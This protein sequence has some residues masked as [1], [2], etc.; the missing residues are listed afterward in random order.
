MWWDVQWMSLC[1][2]SGFTYLPPWRRIHPWHLN[3]NYTFIYKTP[4]AINCPL[5]SKFYYVRIFSNCY[6]H[7]AL[8][9]V[10]QQP[11]FER[12]WPS[13]DHS[14]NGYYLAMLYRHENTDYNHLSS[15][16]NSSNIRKLHHWLEQNNGI[17]PNIAS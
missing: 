6:R 5:H 12:V 2:Q 9:Y 13:V 10:T 14:D 16:I 17:T 11:I 7:A 4:N 3:M 1:C 15:I 8:V